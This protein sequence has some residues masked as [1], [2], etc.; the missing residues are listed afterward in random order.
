MT[1]DVGKLMLTT[2]V[3]FGKDEPLIRVFTKNLVAFVFQEA[4]EFSSPWT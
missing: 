4:G 2:E 1:S 3:L